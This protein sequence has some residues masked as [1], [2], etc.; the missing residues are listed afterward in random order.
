MIRD[1]VLLDKLI[2]DLHFHKFLFVNESDNIFYYHNAEIEATSDC[3]ELLGLDKSL[4]PHTDFFHGGS[5]VHSSQVEH[6]Y[7]YVDDVF[8]D[9]FFRTHS[10]KEIIFPYGFCYQQITP[11]GLV[12]PHSDLTLNLN[13][14]FDRCTFAYNIWRLFGVDDTLHKVFPGNTF[15]KGSYINDK[16]FGLHSH[17]GVLVNEKPFNKL[18]DEYIIKRYHGKWKLDSISRGKEIYD[19]INFIYHESELEIFNCHPS[20]QIKISDFSQSLSRIRDSHIFGDYS[21]EELLFIYSLLT[22]KF[23]LNE[24]SFLLALC[25]CFDYSRKSRIIDEF[26]DFENRVKD[27]RQIEP[28][29]ISNDLCLRFA[30]HNK[31]KAYSFK[32]V[33]D[34]VDN[35][36]LFDKDPTR[37]IRHSNTMPLPYLYKKL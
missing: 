33:N 11:D 18:F 24:D 28:F 17:C 26:I 1:K 34:V 6:I 30:S 25:F 31:S 23:V 8:I 21:I 20:Y 15:I 37:L 29:I 5:V 36:Y 3:M 32:H 4:N 22:D 2:A 10:F 14:I 9:Y 35:V 16:V 12:S 13:N 27:Y 7:N 19:F